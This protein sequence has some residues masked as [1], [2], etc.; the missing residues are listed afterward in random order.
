MYN[1]LKILY[2]A[3]RVVKGGG[4]GGFGSRFTSGKTAISHFTGKKLVISRNL[5]NSFLS[6]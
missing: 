6:V 5:M 2:T 4:G 3:L 1:E